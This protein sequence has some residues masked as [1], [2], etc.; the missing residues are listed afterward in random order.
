MCTTL[1][2]WIESNPA[3][4]TRPKGERQQVSVYMSYEEWEAL[5]KLTLDHR[6]RSIHG[7]RMS[8]LIRHALYRYVPQLLDMLDDDYRP[9]S[10][11]MRA[12]IE[13]AGLGQ[14]LTDIN[15]YFESRGN[16]LRMLLE[17]GE[18]EKAFQ[19]Y[20][21]VLNFVNQRDGVWAPLMRRLLRE[22]PEIMVFRETVRKLGAADEARLR[23]MEQ[24]IEEETHG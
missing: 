5:S 9:V 11:L 8:E 17:I 22:H 14:T 18:T 12:D 15:D 21:H 20:E 24:E 10:E 7:G 3:A 4:P 2:E 19:H 16:E 1:A 6:L 23:I 13:R